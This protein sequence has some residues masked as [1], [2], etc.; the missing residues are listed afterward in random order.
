M[1]RPASFSL[2]IVAGRNQNWNR[3]APAHSVGS[4]FPELA[5]FVEELRTMNVRPHV[6]Q[7]TQRRRSAIDKRTTRHPCYAAGQ[8]IGKR[9]E[10][11]P[12]HGVQRPP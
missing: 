4:V 7:N 11:R 8:R 6:A 9:I 12:Y 3:A 2:E 10:L 1:Q 5:D